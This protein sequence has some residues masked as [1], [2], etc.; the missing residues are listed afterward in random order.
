MNKTYECIT[1]TF[2]DVN[3]DKSN[4]IVNEYSNTY[5]RTI[6]IK[7]VDVKLSTYIEFQVENNDKDPKSKIGGHV[8]ISKAKNIFAKGYTSKWSEEVFVIKKLKIQYHGH[9]Q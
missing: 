4:D 3:I 1:S 8:R 6:K 7:P 2:K 5:K 9:T